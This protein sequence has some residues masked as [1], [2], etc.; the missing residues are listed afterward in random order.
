MVLASTFQV[1]QLSLACQQK[2]VRTISVTNA[3]RL[4]LLAD[5]H[6]CPS[7]AY[8]ARAF[9]RA[10]RGALAATPAWKDLE[11]A[12]MVKAID[13]QENLIDRPARPMVME[14]ASIDMQ[15]DNHV[16]DGDLGSCGPPDAKQRRQ[17]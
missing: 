16:V 1:D 10:H 4:A 13:E 11:A 2:L 8:N 5:A 14:D 12:D 15:N 17:N 6:A 3:C 7:L 9:I